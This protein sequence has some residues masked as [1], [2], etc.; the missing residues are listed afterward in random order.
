MLEL[1]KKRVRIFFDD[2]T[3]Y[4]KKMDGVIIRVDENCIFFRDSHD[5][6]CQ[7]IPLCRVYR[8]IVFGGDDGVGVGRS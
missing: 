6:I 2:G 7:I 8:V 4:V 3:N 5:G 1:E